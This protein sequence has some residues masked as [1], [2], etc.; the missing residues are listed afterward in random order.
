MNT[1]QFIDVI[2]IFSAILI[3]IMFIPQVSHVIKT[4][5]TKAINYFFLL[6]NL[7]A[8]FLGIVYS[9]Y[10]MVVP[11]IIANS[12]ACMFSVSLITL[13]YYYEYETLPK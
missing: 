7:L 10:F 8:S 12:S 5:D 9:I 6:I 11:M 2:G 3:A 4:K 13:K 1:D